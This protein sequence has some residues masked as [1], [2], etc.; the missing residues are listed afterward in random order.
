[1]RQVRWACNLRSVAFALT[2]CLVEVG[3]RTV[4]ASERN[5]FVSAFC[6]VEVRSV[7]LW[8]NLGLVTETSA[9][10]LIL[11]RSCTWASVFA[12]VTF[13]AACSRVEVR[14]R[15]IIA[16]TLILDANATAGSWVEH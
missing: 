7:R 8:L 9:S 2:S 1:M 15:G 13:A 4:R 5:A 6:L 3:K 14:E 11:M 12:Q 16:G 10:T